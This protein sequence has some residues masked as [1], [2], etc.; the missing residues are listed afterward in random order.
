MP[1]MYRT[2]TKPK[3]QGAKPNWSDPKQVMDARDLVV[4]RQR[5]HIGRGYRMRE[6]ARNTPW[7]PDRTLEQVHDRLPGQLNGLKL[8]ETW[9]VES[10][11]DNYTTLT[12]KVHVEPPSVQTPGTDAIDKVYGWLQ[13]NFKGRWE[14][15]GICVCKGIAGYP[16]VWSQHAYCNAI[17]VGGST[18]NLDVI[19]KAAIAATRAG[20]LPID[21]V[22]WRGWEH[23]HGGKVMDHY[24][25][26]HI[27]GRP[28]RSGHP[29]AC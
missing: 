7:G 28:Q 18:G 8:G 12:R 4:G 6:W 26:V 20:K 21:Q 17:D 15:W 3:R 1:L 2:A 23:I 16:G 25:H 9:A 24:D 10:L 5:K 14:N 19:A 29:T 11:K 13:A 27:T 22:I